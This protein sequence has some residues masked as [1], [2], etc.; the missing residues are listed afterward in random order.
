MGKEMDTL[1]LST[2]SQHDFQDPAVELNRKRLEAWLRELPLLNLGACVG[3][4]RQALGP[5]NRQALPDKDRLRL[6]E[7]Y[8]EPANSLFTS[9]DHTRLRQMPLS[10]EQ[11]KQLKE[12]VGSLCLDLAAGYKIAVKHGFESGHSPARDPD[13]LL[14]LQRAMEQ[15]AH[16]LLHSYRVYSAPPEHA[17]LELHQLYRFAEHHKVLDRP[18]ASNP[19]NQTLLQFYQQHMLL[20][21]ADPFRLAEDEAVK[22]LRL[23][24]PYAAACRLLTDGACAP[25][26]GR[27]LI[28]LD[29][30]QVPRACAKLEPDSPPRAPRI[31]DVNQAMA[32]A[33]AALV[34]LTGKYDLRSVEERR[35]LN[36]LLP[37]LNGSYARAVPRTAVQ[38]EIKLAM[39]ITAMH[40][41]LSDDGRHLADSLAPSEYGIEVR[42]LESESE[43]AYTLESWLIVNE[44]VKGYLLT[45]P[46]KGTGDI[47]VG[48]VVGVAVT[49]PG[50]G[51]SF[52]TLAVIRWMRGGRN[53]QVEI[54]AEIIPGNPV[55]MRCRPLDQA[56]EAADIC[57]GLLLPE[58]SVLNIPPTLLIPKK[59]YS[60]G[61]R[62][63]IDTPAQTLVVEA[64][65]LVMDTACF[66]RF[67]FSR[68]EM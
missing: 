58:V 50:G 44:S 56:N 41:F 37:H 26:E 42:D 16:A 61:R 23:L 15:I 25:P 66:D 53:E 38:R 10:S 64:G 9:F 52:L 40:Y 36:L 62:L 20:A 6:L 46:R 65:H 17:Y 45:R 5:L 47:L 30:D 24:H 2:P 34:R 18:F 60:R 48:D 4:L 19:G 49:P 35:L 14:A 28:D 29:A 13:L 22:L 51:R 1:L 68:V 55:G 43:A 8:R 11:R 57:D 31:L 33:Q 39:G 67:Q 3:M 63:R 54:G 32:N 21:I 59:I 12:S 27:F 7:L